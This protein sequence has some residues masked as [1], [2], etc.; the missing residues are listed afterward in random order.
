MQIKGKN[1]VKGQKVVLRQK[2]GAAPYAWF[3][4]TEW[5]DRSAAPG[6]KIAEGLWLASD[7]M[8]FPIHRLFELEVDY[9]VE[10]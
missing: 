3:Q 6:W 10:P 8:P 5:T 1:L 7:V 9:E 2:E 4:F